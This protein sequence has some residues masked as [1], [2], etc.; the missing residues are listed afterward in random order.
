MNKKV[1]GVV[2]PMSE[3]NNNNSGT[4]KINVYKFKKTKALNKDDII[5]FDSLKK[6]DTFMHNQ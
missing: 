2:L 3:I 5:M 4:V 6:I 1:C